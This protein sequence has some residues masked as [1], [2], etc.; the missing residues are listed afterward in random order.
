MGHSYADPLRTINLLCQAATSGLITA[1]SP[2]ASLLCLPHNTNSCIPPTLQ[3]PRRS[4]VLPPCNLLAILCK[5]PSASYNREQCPPRNAKHLLRSGLN[6]T[7]I[8]LR[9]TTC[10]NSDQNLHTRC[11][12]VGLPLLGPRNHAPIPRRLRSD[13][14]LLCRRFL[15][16]LVRDDEGSPEG[17]Q[18]CEDGGLDGLV[19]CWERNRCCVEWAD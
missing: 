5:I 16:N 15:C 10:H 8:S 7:G 19:C 18:A 13:L 1:S 6:S 12:S 14:W 11:Y 3:H 9:L 2:P 4:W 17:E